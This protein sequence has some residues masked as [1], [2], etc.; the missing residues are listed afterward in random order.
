MNKDKYIEEDLERDTEWMA[1]GGYISD[2]EARDFIR[3]LM[4]RFEWAVEEEE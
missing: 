4:T 3:C 1:S 2:E